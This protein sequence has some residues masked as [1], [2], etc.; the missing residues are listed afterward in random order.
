MQH[1]QC[2]LIP[3][4][5]NVILLAHVIVIGKCKCVTGTQLQIFCMFGRGFRVYSFL[6]ELQWAILAGSWLW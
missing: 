4:I 5:L 6:V 3:Y 2:I 1:L